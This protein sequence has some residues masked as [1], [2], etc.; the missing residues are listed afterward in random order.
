MPWV[1]GRTG[2]A[3]G[4]SQQVG[5]ISAAPCAATHGRFARPG[6]TRRLA[7]V[8]VA[9][10]A[11]ARKGFDEI[12]TAA[13]SGAGPSQVLGLMG[14]TMRNCVARHQSYRLWKRRWL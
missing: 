4:A 5:R 8:L 1:D 7:R 9:D 2:W 11:C 12:A 13:A 10:G 3:G 14:E 6:S